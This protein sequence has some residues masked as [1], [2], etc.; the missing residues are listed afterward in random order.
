MQRTSTPYPMSTGEYGRPAAGWRLRMY[1]IIF[2]ADTRTGRLFDLTLIA[3][4]LASVTVVVLD[5]MA[6]VHAKHAAVFN[7]LEWGFTII[8]SVEYIA[9]LA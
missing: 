2:E 7:A 4:I 8:F 6:G 3:F 5:S 1:T 9:R